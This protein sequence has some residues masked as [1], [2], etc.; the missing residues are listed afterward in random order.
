MAKP[1][2]SQKD[3]FDLALFYCSK[4][5]TSAARL[6]QYLN[7][8][9]IAQN[10]E[11]TDWVPRVIEDCLRLKIVDDARF[12]GILA[13]EYERQGKGRRYIEQKLNEKGV[14]KESFTPEKN[15]QAE[16]A[17]AV[18]VAKKFWERIRTRPMRSKAKGRNG[19][20]RS[21]TVLT[22][23]LTASLNAGPTAQQQL[24]LQK[25]KLMQKLVAHGYSFE[26]A[27]KALQA[28]TSQT[29]EETHSE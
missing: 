1:I 19:A 27:K 29:L 28:V 24:Y 16:E 5:E 17:R 7:R 21:S 25:Q 11:N 10:N 2:L 13:R 23:G 26:L 3:L 14:T 9:L 20:D 15:D 4:R 22:A 18:E 6:A 12:G 8:K